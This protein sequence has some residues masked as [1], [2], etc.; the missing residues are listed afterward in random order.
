MPYSACLHLLF[1]LHLSLAGSEREASAAFDL[2]GGAAEDAYEDAIDKRICTTLLEQE[3]LALSLQT[4]PSSAEDAPESRSLETKLR[5][6]KGSAEDRTSRSIVWRLKA[7]IV[8]G[9]YPQVAV[10]RAPRKRFVHVAS[11]TV[12]KP[13]E[14]WEIKYFTRVEEETEGGTPSSA[15]EAPQNLLQR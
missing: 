10:V 14:P 13:P 12:E 6:T 2:A 9:L 7:C 1:A 3:T 4:E 15:S 5:E 11:G 8:A